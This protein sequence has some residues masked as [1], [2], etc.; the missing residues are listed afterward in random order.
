[1]FFNNFSELMA[2]D[3]HGAYVWAV[4]LISLLVLSSQIIIPLGR[5]RR[6]FVQ[7]RMRLRRESNQ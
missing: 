7:Q 2:M 5:S 6:F 4:V 3:G 1:M